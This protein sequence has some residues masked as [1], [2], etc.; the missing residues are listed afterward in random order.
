MATK[1]IIIKGKVIDQNK[2]P[3]PNLRIEA[4]SKELLINGAVGEAKS[5]S[6]GE[7][8]ISF[9]QNRFKKLFLD[10]E[11]DLYFKI[12]SGKKLIH[13]TEKSVIWNISKN[14]ENLIIKIN[15]E[16]VDN[17]EEKFDSGNNLT[18]QISGQVFSSLGKPL[19]GYDVEAFTIT[20]EKK[21][22]V[23][24]TITGANGQ[25]VLN[26]KSE[27]GTAELD[28]QVHAFEKNKRS[29]Y[30]A[31]EVKYNVKEKVV[32]D[33]IIPN[34]NIIIESEFDLISQKIQSN[35]GNLNMNQIKED[36]ENEHI[37]YLSNKTGIDARIVAMNVAAHQ[38]GSDLGLAPSHI[39]AL[40]RSGVPGNKE[41]IQS[42]SSE[43][44]KEAIEK[45]SD[46]N[47]IPK[48]NR[49]DETLKKLSAQKVDFVLNNKPTTAFSSMSDMLSI[50][51][52][53]EQKQI[54]A[55]VQ[56][57]AGTDASKLWS[58]LSQRGFT[59][60][61]IKQLQL[62]GK[63][64]FLTG[65]N[66]NL[67]KKIYS[68]YSLGSEE[69]FVNQ[70][71]YK[72]EKWKPVI[73]DD[74]PDGI[75]A[76]EY[77]TYLSNQIK[78]SYPN[79][80]AA[81]MI[82]S[83]E[84]KLGN[85]APLMEVSAF[86]SKNNSSSNRIGIKPINQWESFT[87]LSTHAKAAAKTFERLYQLSPSD[88][89]MV[90]MS[91]IGI[92]SAY[93]IARY[94]QSE[95]LA[96]YEKLFPNK[97]EALKV[98]TKANEVYSASLNIATGYI[99][100]RAAP[101]VYAIT[102]NLSKTQNSTIAY[103]TLEDLFGNMEYCSCD[104]CKSVLSPAAYFVELLQFI[105]LADIPHTGDNPIDALKERRP[106]IENI[107][108]TCGN[109][110]MALPYIDLVNEI[111]EYY[112]LH[113]NLNNLEG[114]DVTEEDTQAEL[115]A[116]PQF[117]EQS[118]YENQLKE[119]VFPYNLPF[120]QP[121]ETLR[122]IFNLWGVSLGDCLSIFSTPLSARKEKLGLSEDEYKTLT[123]VAH[124]KL[125][126]YFGE[127]ENNT[128][129]Q[130]N[131]AIA[132]GKEFI[133]RVGITYEELVQLLKTNFINPG[134]VLTLKLQKLTIPLLDLQQFY[135]GS[136]SDTDLDAMIPVTIDLADY[137]GDVKEWLK[138]H[139]DLIMGLITLTDVSEAESEC[140][141]AEV[142]LRY[143]LPDNSLNAL[144]AVAYHKF[145]RFLRLMKRTG[146]SIETLD[147]V[148]KSLLPIEPLLITESN[149]DNTFIILLNRMA[150][151]LKLA[152]L[153][154][155]SSKRY[156][157]LL[158]L[159]DTSQTLTLRQI[160]LAK[161]LKINISEMLELATISGFDP[162]AADWEDDEPSLIKFVKTIKQLKINGLKTA[163]LSYL[164]RHQDS[165]GK[166]TLNSDML[167]KHIKLIKDAINKV[168]VENSIAHS[169]VDFELAK[170][171]MM[172]VYDSSTTDRFFGFLLGTGKYTSF[173]VTSEQDLPSLLSSVDSKL[174]FDTFKKELSYTG[175][176]TTTNKTAIEN[177]LNTLVSAD[178]TV[179]PSAADL[180]AFK[181]NFT[182]ALNALATSSN[183]DLTDFS[184][185]F[186]ELRVI[187]DA[188]IAETDLSVQAQQIVSLIL[189]ELKAKLKANAIQQVLISILKVEAEMVKTL[190]NSVDV[191]HAKADA[192]KILRYDFEQLEQKLV[193]DQSKSYEFYIDAPATDDYLLYLTAP[194]NTIVNLSLNGNNIINNV[195][196]SSSGEISNTIPLELKTGILHKFVLN[197]ASLPATQT[198]SLSW[199]TKGMARTP[200]PDAAIYAKEQVDFATVS[201]LR[202]EK[203]TQVSK[204]FKINSLELEY[205]AALNTE[206]KNFLNEIPVTTGIT[207]ADLNILW[208]KINLLVYFQ[209]I[210]KANEP[211]INT[212][213]S[214]LLNPELK[215]IQGNF[216]LESF[217]SWKEAD[218]SSVLNKFG[219]VRADLSLLTKLQKVMEA[220]QIINAIAYPAAQSLTW[221]TN[222]PTYDLISS[223]KTA[224]KK[225]V[226]ERVWLESMQSVNDVVRNKLRDV[227]VSYILQYK[228]PSP[229][230]DNPDKLYEYFLIDVEMDAC[231]K[232]SRIRQA[233]STVQLFI[234][235]CLMN[236]EP[237]V[238]ASS[239]RAEQW[240]WMKR[241]R[242]WEANRKV[243]LYP[244]NWL[245]PELR[246]NKSS[247]FKELEGEMMQQEITDE[248]AELAFLNYLKKLDDIAK[249]EMVGM[250]LEENEQG[251]QD[252]DILH[253]IGRTNGN[254]RQHFYRRYEYGY[255]TPWEKISLNIEGDHVFPIVWKK[256]LFVFWLNILEKPAPMSDTTKSAEYLSK[257]PIGESSKINVEINMCWGEYYKGKW[258]SPK[259]T[260]FNKPLIISNISNFNKKD[261]LLHGRKDILEKPTRKFRERLIF[262]LQYGEP[263]NRAIRINGRTI[264]V[265]Y[266][267]NG[268][269]FTFTS[270]NAPPLVEQYVHDSQLQTNVISPNHTAFKKA[271]AQSSL[272]N[273][274]IDNKG[275]IFSINIAQPINALQSEMK[276]TVFTKKNEL[277]NGFALLPLRHPLENHFE[278]PLSYSDE[279]STLF[280]QPEEN[281]SYVRDS[282]VYYPIPPI[283]IDKP[284]VIIDR[285]RPGWPPIGPDNP[286]FGG[287][288]NDPRL[289]NVLRVYEN[290]NTILPNDAT[291][292]FG[293]INFNLQGKV[294]NSKLKF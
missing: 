273:N 24:K 187:Y 41:A 91:K 247:F 46:Q 139:Q 141:F 5:N 77:A 132:N 65:H 173:F 213:L 86:F 228:S 116:E 95:F 51:L 241:Y 56:S 156:N 242:V 20:I 47:I 11:P 48:N 90:A 201:L 163:D 123:D 227:L 171:K 160:Q 147:A 135:E 42:L 172:L 109:T 263:F 136:L 7:F 165:I 138:Q 278:A 218:L 288:I 98:Y 208:T 292:Q 82:Q 10:N 146:W 50:R 214:V 72:A 149:I 103:P 257:R 282:D 127:P 23:G 105:D 31:S 106:D 158:L 207:T 61:T 60:E 256:R 93:Q 64:G 283:I 57:Q 108:L 32:I 107:K 166:L 63:L 67:V 219:F 39:Y 240:A 33:V 179:A 289:G 181:V 8:Q 276:E 69:D 272:D 68:T 246:D 87:E 197:I 28:V 235:R 66:A 249:L 287:V 134:Y 78:L 143:A 137:D 71:L 84:V 210:K 168:E 251:N 153:F 195:T 224:I 121:L 294:G 198:L 211:E 154:A 151:F 14:I 259:S 1:N 62:D 4:W 129:A 280:A 177:A 120:H 184:T 54:F 270:K 115:L 74:L 164:L 284:P 55:E 189:P 70:K 225:H 119:E 196:I 117:V 16:G 59:K 215:N 96:S 182:I 260:E 290:I 258:T 203:A 265:A 271:D 221:I 220:M 261:L 18:C 159:F 142:E 169:N 269:Q 26:F 111:L 162:F 234:Q 188:V 170:S 140:N 167:L 83:E 22:S 124:K 267:L 245:E 238:D 53:N 128:I 30:F 180:A 104:H 217:N 3:V 2:K 21:R 17:N 212:W 279:R 209:S 194:Q 19:D 268:G 206:T 9:T 100:Q 222:D 252:D 38:I 130:L 248:S 125:P 34:E 152:D 27:S 157:D 223:I 264:S 239:I 254:T 126:R 174:S 76:D 122:R 200:I 89:S 102:G 133:R 243:F 192:S 25:Y 216:L 97:S 293:G 113:D 99:T 161:V 231:M 148:M 237:T 6:K 291:F 12:F 35:F 144:K 191:L 244:E 232:S 205:F 255:W 236:L 112:I 233:I 85:N 250:Y 75:S 80:V 178:F 15:T 29:S 114:H 150:N 88:E 101:N 226:T 230:I 176:L 43:I 145:H 13:S 131:T 185:A 81:S 155:Y 193:F 190:A 262:D 118:V 183:N 52:N 274:R 36:G 44:I 49:T 37:T 286:D 277:S 175:I 281:I 92:N 229:E 94:T 253:V 45:A 110:N 204:V 266:T 199:R 186:P 275:K 58:N 73:K 79:L 40:F 285:P 202:I